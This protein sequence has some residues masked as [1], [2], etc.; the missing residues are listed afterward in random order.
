MLE[1]KGI[2]KRFPGVIANYRVDF[3]L[4]PGEV[5]TLLGE[6][7][8][9]KSTLMKVLYGL[10][11]ADEGTIEIDGHEVALDSPT[12]A[13]DHG[14]GMV[15]QHFML[16]PTLTVAE[17]VALG[18]KSSRGFLTDLD[19]VS[20]RINELTS[21]YGLELDPSALVWQ[22]SVGE[23]QRVEI[24]KA[25][26]RDA[27]LL[28]LDEPTAVLTPQE[29]EQLFVTLRQLTDDGRGLIF[30]S[31]KL[32]EVLA[33]SSRITVLRHG[34]VTGEIPVEGAT[35]ESLA[36]MMVGRAVKLTPDKLP[37]EP[38][39]VAL[40]IRDLTVVGDRG[41]VAVDHLDLD[42]RRGE[43][44]GIAGVSGNGQ[45]ELAE[46]IAGLRPIE[47]GT[48]KVVDTDVT[49]AHPRTVR[50]AGL[51]YVPEERMRE[52]AIADFTVWENLLLIDYV[53][54][55]YLKRGLFDFGTIEDHAEELVA[56]FDV[57]TPSIGTSCG[58]LSGGNIQK[59]ILA[60]ELSSSPT[61]LVASQPTRGV[62]IGAAEYIHRRLIDKRN[63]LTDAEF[64]QAK[65]VE[66]R[67]A[68]TAILMISED[69][70]EVF[71][72]ADRI[73]VLYEGRIMDIVDPATAT[74]EQVGLLMAGVH[75]EDD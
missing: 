45:R 49:G 46:T 44:L 12:S 39:D 60:R 74:R 56:A 2:T 34:E 38:G 5:H 27:R 51:A 33:L 14:I 54:D 35:R 58:S 29:V 8:A 66:H 57:R 73:A 48:I 75:P 52:G 7:G 53:S 25:L 17:N 16:V 37:A 11:P 32:H 1:M 69:L 20:E 65:L 40:E 18:L 59:L 22:L 13:I 61:V 42:V 10:Y 71:G 43:I 41:L 70:D 9:G 63:V 3:D 47:S 4:Y 24:I 72:L 68:C 55:E 62:D 21:R 31:H 15:H 6:N 50:E 19:V 23:R 28:I 36:N 67:N 64:I 26:Y 30:I